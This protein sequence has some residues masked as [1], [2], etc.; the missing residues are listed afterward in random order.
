MRL[1]LCMPRYGHSTWTRK[2]SFLVGPA[3]RAGAI[4]ASR[5]Q[6]CSHASANG[7]SAACTMASFASC[8]VTTSCPSSRRAL[9][10]VA[11]PARA[12][13]AA[14]SAA[15]RRSAGL[16]GLPTSVTGMA[17][18]GS[19]RFGAAAGSGTRSAA[20]A[21][22]SSAVDGGARGEHDVGDGDLA[23]V[24]V[25]AAD[26][27]GGA[28]RGVREQG[29]LDHRGV[30]VVAAADDEVLGPAGQVDVAVGVDRAEV[31]GV[32]PAVADHVPARAG[33]RRAARGRDSR[34]RRRAPDDQHAD[35][36]GRQAATGP[37][38]RRSAT[39]LTLLVGQARPTV[40]G[41]C[42]ARDGERGG[43]G[44]LGQP[45]ALAAARRRFARETRR[46]PP[47]AA[48]RRRRSA[49]AGC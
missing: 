31:A 48:A 43:A 33:D 25:R 12:S 9:T 3:R 23:G 24:P 6:P 34:R 11:R 20:Q 15:R 21:S 37:T 10:A 27:R 47:A 35:L 46:A 45:V 18:M 28:D 39:A 7:P 2:S 5:T 16:K 29:V 40:P 22:S 17:S 42:A 41:A 36:A 14:S 38:P 44:G 26:G 19:T 30:D 1:P 13:R 4:R 32:E 49:A 8:T